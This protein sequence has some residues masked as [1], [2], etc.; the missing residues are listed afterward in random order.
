MHTQC[1]N[2]FSKPYSDMYTSLLLGCMN[3]SLDLPSAVVLAWWGQ[4]SERMKS[5][6]KRSKD[7]TWKGRERES[8]SEQR[9]KK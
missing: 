9:W 6:A 3:T 8:N 5:D 1:E 7:E 4:P 2:H